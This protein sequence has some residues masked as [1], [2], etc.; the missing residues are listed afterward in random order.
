MECEL[1]HV[2]M[3]MADGMSNEAVSVA[4]SALPGCPS[5]LATKAPRLDIE[6]CSE[7]TL[8]EDCEEHLLSFKSSDERS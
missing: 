7:A 8:T 5:L 2:G 6:V 4:C 3:W 1:D